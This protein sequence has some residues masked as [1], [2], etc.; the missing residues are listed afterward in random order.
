MKT[1]INAIKVVCFKGDVDWCHVLRCLRVVEIREGV[2]VGRRGV[3]DAT[4][5]MRLA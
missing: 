1:V 3:G 5:G 4:Q 2:R